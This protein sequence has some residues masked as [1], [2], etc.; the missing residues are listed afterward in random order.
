[1]PD[2]GTSDAVAADLHRVRVRRDE[3]CCTE[4]DYGGEATVM[5]SLRELA[6]LITG[7]PHLTECSAFAALADGEVMRVDRAKII[8]VVDLCTAA[9]MES[10][11][12]EAA[13]WGLRMLLAGALV[14]ADCAAAGHAQLAERIDVAAALILH[15]QHAQQE[16]SVGTVAQ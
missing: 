13:V 12:P 11:Y 16:S 7:E 5:A 8:A 10:G 15:S 3:E 9:A 4:I 1:M 6:S 14:Y 2:P